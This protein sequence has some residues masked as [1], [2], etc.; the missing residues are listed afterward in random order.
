MER[1]RISEENRRSVELVIMVEAGS[2]VRE[3]GTM[4][5]ERR[6]QAYYQEYMSLISEIPV[7]RFVEDGVRLQMQL[8]C[9]CV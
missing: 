8:R 1:Y 3:M 5:K 2:I 6:E 4:T 7:E 9:V